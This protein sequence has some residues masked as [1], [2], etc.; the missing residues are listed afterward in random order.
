MH[1][2]LFPL[3]WQNRFP[4]D[5]L[6]SKAKIDLRPD[7][8][9]NHL[10][11]E[12]SP[13][14]LQHA[15]NPVDWY[16]WGEAAFQKARNEDKPIFLSIGYSTC[17]WCHV[18]AHESF[19]DE[20]VADILNRAF[21]CI[22]VD[23]EE[24]PDVDE[25]Y[26]LATQIFT[27]QGGWPN[28]LWL[29]HG[30]KPW[31][32]GTYFPKHDRQG[33][34]GFISLLEALERTWED[35]R[36]DVERQADRLAKA[37]R[38]I[39]IQQINAPRQEL[40]IADVER[41]SRSFIEDFDPHSGGFGHAPKFP[42]HGILALLLRD[43]PAQIS[44]DHRLIVEKT[45]DAMAEG[46]IYDH[47]GGGFHRYA[48]D[49]EWFLPHFEKMLYD[50]AQLLSIY[51]RAYAITSATR[52]REVIEETF[53][54]L[55]REMR[56]PQGGFYS[57]LD[58]DSD[59]E[60]GKYYV[61][62]YRE[63]KEVV[64]PQWMPLFCKAFGVTEG[65]NYFEEASRTSTGAN[66]IFQALTPE[67]A[68]RLA[69][70][71]TA[72]WKEQVREWKEQLLE[73]REQRNP[74]H[75]DDKILCSWNALLISGLIE[76]YQWCDRRDYLDSAIHAAEFIHEVLRDSE[77]RL[78]HSWRNGKEGTAGYLE[79]YA[80]LG[81]SFL[82]LYEATRESA[83]LRRAEAL[84]DLMLELFQDPARGGFFVSSHAHDHLLWRSKGLSAGG[85]IPD[86][87]GV[88]AEFLLRLGHATSHRRY[89]E[90]GIRTINAFSHAIQNHP[91][92]AE[93]MV[94][95]LATLESLDPERKWPRH[96]GQPEEASSPIR[97]T[98]STNPSIPGREESQDSF[99]EVEIN[100][101]IAPGHHIYGAD[102]RP[103]LYVPTSLSLEG[104]AF[105]LHQVHWPEAESMEDQVFGAELPVYRGHFTI[106]AEVHR[107]IHVE[108]GSYTLAFHLHAQPCNQSACMYPSD[109]IV[110]IEVS[111]P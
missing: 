109:I 51:A 53:Q 16:P 87:N 12:S 34:L 43:I 33:R 82:D 105:S 108:P 62:R 23:R 67:N 74:P 107:H 94:I 100:V 56:H 66:I 2:F 92:A 84:A 5:R 29:D 91:R 75:L 46:G 101:E 78:I 42:P 41:A 93:S 97:A 99:I 69:E 13:Y 64:G 24:R 104:E 110:P 76:A 98:A 45:L 57:A 86:P 37:L 90:A 44:E 59:G 47:V 70:M 30:L 38:N 28:S 55:Q 85:N 96:P 49:H 103:D 9:P 11:H 72:Q 111:I 36:E 7:P 102:L 63:I 39:S 6:N 32:A 10:L 31:F 61:W 73:R 26:M 88:A 71:P 19:E 3:Q 40:S 60:E 68:A 20:Q 35:R 58:A 21:V 95:S 22:K 89:L 106:Q 52:Y 83:W 15:E 17:H 4:D 25:Q 48:T 81:R 8:M 14:L 18:M 50:N 65:G 54:W 27:G 79:D 77:G 1:F 80:F